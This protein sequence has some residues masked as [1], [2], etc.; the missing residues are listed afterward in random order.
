MTGL[1]VHLGDFKTGTTAIQSWLD[2]PG[3]STG[4]LA[5]G[6]GF[7]QA[8]LVAAIQQGPDAADQA[9]AALA[10]ALGPP[11]GRTAILS[12][13]HFEYLD[14]ARL[15]PLIE[16]HLGAWARDGLRL[17]AYI[18]PHPAALVSR[19]AES[20]KIGNFAGDL[21]AY[22]EEPSLRWRITYA[23]RLSAWEAVFGPAFEPRLFRPEDLLGGDV[24]RDFLALAMGRDPGPLDWPR[25][26]RRP[27]AADLA[28]AR[29]VHRA[30]GALPPE[31]QGARWTLG[32]R[33][34][35]L[36]AERRESLGGDQ[37]LRL[38][39]AVALRLS[40]R[41]AADAAAAEERF[42]PDRGRPLSQALAR[43]VEDA[44]TE[45]TPIEPE[46]HWGP[47]AL[48]I[49]ELWGRMLGEGLR[50]PGGPAALD[51]LFHE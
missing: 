36:L 22:L 23:R 39:R 50:A 29:A 5:Y 41:F 7:N 9:F 28:L 4:G 43:A 38:H 40:E 37:P 13:E 3:R 33:L 16:R 2:G 19:F 14:P 47:E 49:A 20:A 46:E 45:P 26:N 21:A 8:G 25:D 12:A 24:L 34:G 48:G 42:W 27:G 17:V 11:R 18:R 51:G 15:A 6:P 31:A 44:P 32:R 1:V 10:A 35:R 30:M